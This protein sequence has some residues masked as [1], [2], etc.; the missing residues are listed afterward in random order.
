MRTGGSGVGSGV[1]I[2]EDGLI[3]TNAHV[4]GPRSVEINVTLS[5]LERVSAQLIGWDVD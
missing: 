2:S 5:N 3:L 4:A 1:I